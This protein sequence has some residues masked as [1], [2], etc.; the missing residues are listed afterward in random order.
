MDIEQ[1]CNEDRTRTKG[2][3]EVKKAGKK[4]VK[5]AAV[6]IECPADG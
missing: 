3:K 4:A 1:P 6:E 2:E 5:K